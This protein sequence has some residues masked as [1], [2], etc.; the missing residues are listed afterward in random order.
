MYKIITA[1]GI[2]FKD[3]EGS[4][5]LTKSDK[6]NEYEGEDGHKTVESIRTDVI[7]ASVTYKGLTVEQLQTMCQA[8]TT[9]TTFILFDATTNSQRQV[10]A[11]VKD[12]KVNK[13][14]HKNDLSVWSLSFDIAEL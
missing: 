7:S 4:F 2:S 3:P 8:L 9:V 13:V 1:N 10:T 12:I 6:I 5:S 14:Y 11:T